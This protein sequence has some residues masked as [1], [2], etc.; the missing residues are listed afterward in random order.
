MIGERSLFRYEL[1][2]VLIIKDEAVYIKEW[3]DYHLLIGI[4]HFYVYDNDSSDNL[5]EILKPYV[6]DG[7]VT[8]HSIAGK[9]AQCAAYNDAL[10]RYRFDCRYMIC[11]DVDEF[12]YPK[13]NRRLLELVDETFAENDSASEFAIYWQ[14]FG[15]SGI[16]TADFGKGV[17]DRFTLRA[18]EDAEQ[19]R[20]FK[21]IVNP[22]EIKGFV[23]PHFAIPFKGRNIVDSRGN[24]IR[25]FI[26]GKSIQIYGQFQNMT[27]L[28]ALNHYVVKSR[29]EYERKI[30]RG[31]AF[32][33]SNPRN[34][35]NFRKFD[36]ND[37]FDDGIIK[38]RDELMSSER[39]TGIKNR[40]FFARIL[41]AVLEILSPELENNASEEFY[42]GQMH[43]F[44][45]CRAAVCMLRRETKL[46]TETES[47]LLEEAAINCMLKSIET[48]EEWQI[49]LLFYELPKLLVRPFPAVEEIKKI[50]KHVIIP[51]ILVNFRV[52]RDWNNYMHFEFVNQFL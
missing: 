40:K 29:E 10:G 37:V 35:E 33:A 6:A 28:I 17:L 19:N 31:D 9:C 3:L 12:I 1:A 25:I 30:A 26:Q 15:S 50:Y 32:Y 36:L 7:L 5:T 8:Y 49:E 13:N 46:L 11:F 4:D 2:A 18:I 44:M 24:K 21:T 43:I 34:E 42:R 41:N 39:Y 51:N 27:E 23:D 22:R 47:N 45:T 48:A 16:K 20:Y 14:N 38:Y 52:H